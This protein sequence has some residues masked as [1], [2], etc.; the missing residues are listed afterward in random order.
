MG[1]RVPP[2]QFSPHLSSGPA[3]SPG[4][5]CG[6]AAGPRPPGRHHRGAK[7]TKGDRPRGCLTSSHMC[8]W[9]WPQRGAI[10]GTTNPAAF[11][12]P[13]RGPQQCAGELTL[14][15]QTQKV[16]PNI[17]ADATQRKSVFMGTTGL[18]PDN[19]HPPLASIGETPRQAGPGGRAGLSHRDGD[20]RR[21][22]WGPKCL[23]DA[24]GL[25]KWPV[26]CRKTDGPT[27][28]HSHARAHTRAHTALA[29]QRH[30]C[31]EWF[32][33]VS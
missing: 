19:V 16:L 33:R 2:G 29:W 30:S 1:Q 8:S 26:P 17:P 24:P 6:S 14:Q 11:P 7:V 25:Q 5:L 12:P 9:P 13:S 27:Y 18:P 22:T 4:Y 32:G 10:S 20:T 21:R 15:S 3:R 23:L 31:L 28:T